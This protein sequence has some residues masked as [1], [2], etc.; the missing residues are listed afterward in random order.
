[1]IKTGLYVGLL[2]AMAP[3]LA[4]DVYVADTRHTQASFE[5]GHLGISWIR[6]RF[7][8]VEAKITLD[9]A[10]KKGTID[11]VIHTASFDAG[12]ELRDKAVR[13]ENYL[14]VEKFPRMTFRSTNLKFEGETLVSAEGEFTLMGITKPL[15]LAIPMFKCIGPPDV[16][17]E[18]CGAEARAQIKRSEFGI[19]RSSTGI[20]DDVKILINIEAIKQ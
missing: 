7:N 11:A 9:R 1:M 14:N 2:L 18:V 15:T 13:S 17:Q 5:V 12:H 20:N 16:R 10:A 6:G 19:T 4:Q 3:A 8:S